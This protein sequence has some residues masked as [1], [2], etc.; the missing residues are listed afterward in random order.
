MFLH[1]IWGNPQY[2]Q[3]LWDG[4]IENSPD[5][6]NLGVLVDEKLDM[7]WKYVFFGPETKQILGWIE[8][9]NPRITQASGEI[10]LF[11]ILTFTFTAQDEKCFM[12]WGQG[13][14]DYS[15]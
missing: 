9:K 6:K 15:V 4:E 13:P 3:R 10:N 8:K 7:S 11:Q 2:E 14:K 1:L 12:Q 5:K